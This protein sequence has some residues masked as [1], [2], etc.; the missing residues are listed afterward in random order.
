MRGAQT[1]KLL[2]AGPQPFVEGIGRLDLATPKAQGLLSGDAPTDDEPETRAV[3]DIR[4]HWLNTNA[5]LARL[6]ALDVQDEAF[7]AIACM[8]MD[9]E[10]LTLSSTREPTAGP[11]SVFEPQ[12]LQIEVAASWLR[13]AGAR[14][15]GC[16][17]I[18]GPKGNLNWEKNRGCPGGS[19][20]T[21]DGVDGCH[22]DRWAH[23]KGILRE[24]AEGSWRRNVIEAAQVSPWDAIVALQWY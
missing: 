21:W 23:W 11:G 6:W 16:K 5:F 15:Y 2:F 12:E 9:L 22:P 19:G 10:P 3:V 4:K 14:M 17:E 24:V 8:R 13:I 1:D 18:M 7:F 20:G